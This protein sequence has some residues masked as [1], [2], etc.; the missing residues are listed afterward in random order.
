MIHKDIK[1]WLTFLIFQLCSLWPPLPGTEK[2]CS[3]STHTKF[4]NHKALSKYHF[5]HSVTWG[6]ILLSCH[7][8]DI[9]IS[10]YH[11]HF[12]VVFRFIRNRIYS[13]SGVISGSGEQRS[14]NVGIMTW[15]PCYLVFPPLHCEF[16]EGCFGIPHLMV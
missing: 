15:S 14:F 13:M 2:W 5:H 8:S 10:K 1:W 11:L 12:R 3:F 4:W 7:D 6:L 16:P 9:F